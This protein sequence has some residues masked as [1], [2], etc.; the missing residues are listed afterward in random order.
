MNSSFSTTLTLT[1]G[2]KTRF[3]EHQFENKVYKL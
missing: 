2:N 3:F 1:I